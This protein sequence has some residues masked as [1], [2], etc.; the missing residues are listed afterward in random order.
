MK[1][2]LFD[3]ESY[4]KISVYFYIHPQKSSC[5]HFHIDHNAMHLVYLPKFCIAIVSN[6][7]GYFAVIPRESKDNAYAKFREVNKVHYGLC[8]ISTIKLNYIDDYRKLSAMIG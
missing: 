3:V 2:E 1:E 8:E 5:H 6:S 7:P 4:I